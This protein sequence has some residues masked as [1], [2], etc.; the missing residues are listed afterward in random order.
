MGLYQNYYGDVIKNHWIIKPTVETNSKCLVQL[1]ELRER[2]QAFAIVQRDS[3]WM[4]S[5]VFPPRKR[6]DSK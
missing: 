4:R 2:T 3:F 6:C 1:Q 5:V